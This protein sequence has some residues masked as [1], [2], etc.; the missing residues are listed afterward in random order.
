MV[1]LTWVRGV[2]W[3]AAASARMA[4]WVERPWSDPSRSGWRAMRAPL[5]VALGLGVVTLSLIVIGPWRL[6]LEPVC[7]SSM[8]AFIVSRIQR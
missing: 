4:P 1:A 5:V 2:L 8:G 7:A 3:L 6:G